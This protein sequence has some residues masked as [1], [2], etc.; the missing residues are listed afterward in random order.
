MLSKAKRR[1]HNG[2]IVTSVES[3]VKGSDFLAICAFYAV[4]SLLYIGPSEMDVRKKYNDSVSLI[5]S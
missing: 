5:I 3:G 4:R 2:S 1:R